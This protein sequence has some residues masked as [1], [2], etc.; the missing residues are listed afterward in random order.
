ME[1]YDTGDKIDLD[2]GLQFSLVRFTD[3]EESI[4]GPT[5]KSHKYYFLKSMFVHLSG[6]CTD[7]TM[8]CSIA[9][10]KVQTHF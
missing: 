10:K 5:L 7:C 1:K 9:A 4:M 8:K 2:T 3:T 6:R